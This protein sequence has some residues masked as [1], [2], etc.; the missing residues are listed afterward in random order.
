MTNTR[1]AFE[2]WYAAEDQS[3]NK[4]ERTYEF[5]QDG[6]NELTK[7][8]VWMGW[9]AATLAAQDKRKPLTEATLAK[10]FE[11]FQHQ[12]EATRFSDFNWF[13]S[14]ATIAEAAHGIKQ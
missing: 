8:C 12:P 3:D 14:G 4:P 10:L 7:D 1:D 6:V 13:V 2:A 9:Q 11:A 5:S